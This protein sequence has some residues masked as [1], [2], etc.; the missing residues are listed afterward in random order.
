[1]FKL[2]ANR[3]VLYERMGKKFIA[4]GKKDLKVKNGF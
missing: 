4:A 2:V 3:F 1:M